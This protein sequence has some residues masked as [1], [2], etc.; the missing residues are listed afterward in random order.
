MAPQTWNSSGLRSGE[1][2]G[3]S[4]FLMKFIFLLVQ[5]ATLS[6]SVKVS[7]GGCYG[8]KGCLYVVNRKG[9][10]NGDYYT[11]ILLPKLMEDCNNVMPNDVIFH[12]D[13]APAHMSR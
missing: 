3:H 1:L 7:A 5:R 8:S 6:G 10:I 13:G 11:N 12:L 2:G 9:R 4:S